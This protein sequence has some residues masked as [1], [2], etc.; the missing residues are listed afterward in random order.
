MFAA[1][2]SKY[3]D[4]LTYS[5]KRIANILMSETEIFQLT[6]EKVAE[7]VGCGQS[8]VIRFSQKLGYNS[9]KDL[10]LDLGKDNSYALTNQLDYSEELSETMMKV[11]NIYDLSLDDILSANEERYIN[12][13]VNLLTN[14][15]CVL[16]F[17][18]KSSF[19]MVS[20]MYYRL[21]ET[22]MPV[23]KSD[24]CQDAVSI[25]SSLKENDV[26]FV[27]SLSG[28]NKEIIPVL[29]IAKRRKIKIISITSTGKRDNT[30]RKMSDVGLKC[31][32]NDVHTK[33]F[34]LINRTAQ[35]Y[36]IDCIFILLWKRNEE[37]FMNAIKEI[38]EEMGSYS[39]TVDGIFS[40]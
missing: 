33:R 20:L 39:L 2:L 11:K 31:G 5:D 21:I 1:T 29:N 7:K 28:E 10:I 24:N 40:L 32:T 12:E 13:A 9:F 16:C 30:I 18:I 4:K 8:T 19:S 17:G 14:A 34:N 3:S 15:H 26:I 36:L 27:V 25:A 23:F 6:S 38:S 37:R 22:G 35:L